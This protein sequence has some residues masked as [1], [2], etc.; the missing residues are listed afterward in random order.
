MTYCLQSSVQLIQ[1]Y[2]SYIWGLDRVLTCGNKRIGLVLKGSLKVAIHITI[3]W[4]HRENSIGL[5][6]ILWLTLRIWSADETKPAT[7][8][9]LLT[10][11]FEL[12]IQAGQ[13]NIC[14]SLIKS[15]VS[16]TCMWVIGSVNCD[17]QQN[18]PCVFK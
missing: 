15:E 7:V 11:K 14:P 9:H 13:S 6:E 12:L 3:F 1:W 8:N 10:V 4:P 18:F 2:L 17:D 16:A 5:L